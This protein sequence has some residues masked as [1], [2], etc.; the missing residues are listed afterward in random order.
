MGE[1]IC[2][3]LVKKSGSARSRLTFRR[4][5]WRGCAPKAPRLRRLSPMSSGKAMCCSCPE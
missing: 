5:R 3:N 1:P 2:R 4:S